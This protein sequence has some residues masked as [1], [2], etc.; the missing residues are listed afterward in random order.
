MSDERYIIEEQ[1]HDTKA[2]EGVNDFYKFG[3]LEIADLFLW[4]W[5]GDLQGKHVLEIGCGD[6]GS[7]VR[8]ARMG[9]NVSCIDISGEM[10]ELTKKRANE[11][12]VSSKVNARKMTGEQLDFPDQQFDIIYGHSVLHHLD[13]QLAKQHL[14][15]VLKPNGF[16]IFL[17]PLNYNPILN[18]FRVF[19]PH[20]RTPTEKP[21]TFRQIK[22]LADS[23]SRWEHKEF[24][25]ISLIAFF[26]YYV[27]RNRNLFNATFKILTPVDRLLFKVFPPL[28][29]L[30]WVTIVKLYT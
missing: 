19:T 4:S 3:A 23:F 15:R 2:L 22:F 27:L 17:E 13:L 8:F 24:H 29:K 10:V 26:W 16:G 25:L 11:C 28:S 14:A 7:T 30:A 21:L 6:G 1:F 9:A 5:M 12:G 18:L 20:R